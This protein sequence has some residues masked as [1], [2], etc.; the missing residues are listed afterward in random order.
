MLEIVLPLVFEEVK[1]S[2]PVTTDHSP[3]VSPLPVVYIL[4]AGGQRLV[5]VVFEYNSN[6]KVT[7]TSTLKHQIM[8]FDEISFV[9]TTNEIICKFFIQTK[10]KFEK[11]KKLKKSYII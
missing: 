3:V 9:L 11:L 2:E 8:I 6:V 1:V 7:Y 5:V 10:H 4:V